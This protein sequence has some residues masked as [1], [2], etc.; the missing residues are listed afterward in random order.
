MAGSFQSQNHE[1]TCNM[2][3][4]TMM[5]MAALAVGVSASSRAQCKCMLSVGMR[6]FF[7]ICSQCSIGSDYCHRMMQSPSIMS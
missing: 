2:S 1:K 3:K 7:F 4:T 5:M 6:S